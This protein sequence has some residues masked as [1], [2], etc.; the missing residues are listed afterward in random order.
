MC[1]QTIVIGASNSAPTIEGWELKLGVHTRRAPWST[2]GWSERW[3]R[4]TPE[5]AEV[6]DHDGTAQLLLSAAANRSVSAS[7]GLGQF[8]T[9]HD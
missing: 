7:L 4:A 9:T 5:P 2:S 3:P 8:S 1:S 6:T